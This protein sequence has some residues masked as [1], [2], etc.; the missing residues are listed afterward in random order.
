MYVEYTKNSYR[1]YEIID[2]KTKN[3]Y[4]FF[5]NPYWKPTPSRYL[6]YNSTYKL[7]IGDLQ[8]KNVLILLILE[9]MYYIH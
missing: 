6:S 5:R 4:I 9:N 8:A 7:I 3:L 1:K 2:V